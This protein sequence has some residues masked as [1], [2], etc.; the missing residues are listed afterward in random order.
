VLKDSEKLFT[1]L[2]DVTSN[3]AKGLGLVNDAQ[4][5]MIK[6]GAKEMAATFGQGLLPTFLL[7]KLDKIGFGK[8]SK[9]ALDFMKD[10]NTTLKQDF[11]KSLKDILGMMKNMDAKGIVKS[12]LAGFAKQKV[13]QAFVTVM[14]MATDE[15]FKL[16]DAVIA[17]RQNFRMTTKEA[18]DL[19][20]SMVN[21]AINTGSSLDEA[22]DAAGALAKVNLRGAKNMDEYGELTLKMSQAWGMSALEAAEFEKTANKIYGVGAAGL[23]GIASAFDRIGRTSMMSRKELVEF[24]KSLTPLLLRIPKTLRSQV[25]P[26]VIATIGAIS[27]EFK[28]MGI[29]PQFVVE[30][31]QALKDPISSEGRKLQAMIVGYGGATAKQFT[32]ALHD[33]DMGVIMEAQLK[34]VQNLKKRIGDERFTRNITLY[35]KAWGMTA[36]QLQSISEMSI[37]DLHD[38][39]TVSDEDRKNLESFNKGWDDFTSSIK[40]FKE[41]IGNVFKGFLM[42][43]GKPLF[44]VLNAITSGLNWFLSL[45]GKIDKDTKSFVGNVVGLAGFALMIWKIVAGWSTMAGWIE[46]AF[47]WMMKFGWFRTLMP[48]IYNGIVSIVAALGFWLV[49]IV[50]VVAAVVLLYKVWKANQDKFMKLFDRMAPILKK[51]GLIIAGITLLFNPMLIPILAVAGAIYAVYKY[52]DDFYAAMKPGLEDLEGAWNAIVEAVGDVVDQLSEALGPAQEDTAGFGEIIT[53]V[54]KG[55]AKAIGTVASWVST[56]VALLVHFL[57]PAI[58]GI[59]VVL[60]PIFKILGDIFNKKAATSWGDAIIDVFYQIIRIV[61]TPFRLIDNFI[62]TMFGFSPIDKFVEKL[63]GFFKW[64]TDMWAVLKNGVVKVW[65]SIKDEVGSFVEWMIKQLKNIGRSLV[66]AIPGGSTVLKMLGWDAPEPEAQAQGGI[67]TGR[68]TIT[69]G[70]GGQPEA[71]VPLSKMKQVAK[72]AGVAHPQQQM[73]SMDDVI[74]AIKHLEDTMVRIS[75]RSGA[76]AMVRTGGF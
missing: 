43:I 11:G 14:Q 51:I 22:A 57:K 41:K 53:K 49:A 4:L 67:A 21:A 5:E 10:L 48:I 37:K 44:Y 26:Q 32:K 59:G 61:Y 3:V 66:K 72:D 55:V 9:L 35:A 47:F 63:K 24:S 54:F 71:I 23:T 25:A 62:K 39:V 8:E 7:G 30:K 42:L 69:V 68:Q 36:E 52:W 2:G 28:D 45:L 6:T 31:L 1:S 74:A 70:E 29:D 75:N 33:N 34:A 13:M 46:T 64:V 27:A 15:A 56:F 65:A 17:I 16:N 18:S 58:T 40:V 38:R 19:G 73:M 76:A 60:E 50:A 12:L 20:D